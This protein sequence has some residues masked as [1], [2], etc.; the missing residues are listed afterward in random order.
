LPA[1]LYQ[2]SLTQV[3]PRPPRHGSWLP[4]PPRPL[5]PEPRQADLA[6]ALAAEF[7]PPAAEAGRALDALAAPLA[8]A[9]DEAPADQLGACAEAVAA[10]FECSDLDWSGIQDLLLD[11]VVLAGCGHPLTVAVACVEAGRRAG[12]PLGIVAGGAGCFVAHPQLGE[13]LLIDTAAG[14]RLV[15]PGGRTQDVGWQCSHQVAARILNRIGERAE[16]L[17][18]VAWA[19]RAAELRLALPFEGSTRERLEADLRRVRARLN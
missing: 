17:N 4:S 19:L 18:H 10:R 1:R 5:A 3:S 2:G 16:R 15:D 9:R 6:L 13:P 12:I 14:G 11:R 8:P 7:R